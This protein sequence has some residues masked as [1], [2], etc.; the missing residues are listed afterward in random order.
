V[1]VVNGL[2]IAVGEEEVFVSGDVSEVLVSVL[3]LTSGERRDLIMVV[4]ECEHRAEKLMRGEVGCF[5]RVERR[6]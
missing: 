4:N 6:G 5:V 3:C 1:T 2:R